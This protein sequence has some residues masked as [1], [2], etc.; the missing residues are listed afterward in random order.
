MGISVHFAALT[1]VLCPKRFELKMCFKSIATL[2]NRAAFSIETFTKVLQNFLSIEHDCCETFANCF[3]TYSERSPE[4]LVW[5]NL[6]YD[7][8]WHLLLR[9]YILG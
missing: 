7:F 8:K 4:F 5:L 3:D 6:E 1:L 2:H 9:T